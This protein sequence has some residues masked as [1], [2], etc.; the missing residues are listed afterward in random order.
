MFYWSTLLPPSS[1]FCLEL[2][3]I[4]NIFRYEVI[5]ALMHGI[6]LFSVPL[7]SVLKV[8]V[9]PRGTMSASLHPLY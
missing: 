7:T 2:S 9:R 4:E 8:S 5:K 6:V 3:R 1:V